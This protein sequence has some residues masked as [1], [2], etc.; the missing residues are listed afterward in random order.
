MLQG[1]RRHG[2]R[3][4]D[5]IKRHHPW[6]EWRIPN[7]TN[8]LGDALVTLQDPGIR[9]GGQLSSQLPGRA[10]RILHAD[11][12]AGLRPLAHVPVGAAGDRAARAPTA[13]QLV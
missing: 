9:E 6:P 7:E 1:K 8:R 2:S 10:E 5:P 12:L 4:H 11:Q 13:P 3:E